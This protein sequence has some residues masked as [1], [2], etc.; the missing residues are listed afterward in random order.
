MKDLVLLEPIFNELMRGFSISNSVKNI[1]PI[2]VE[3][4]EDKFLI[5]AE[6]PGF[7]KEDINVELVDN[8]IIIKAEKKQEKKGRG[9]SEIQYGLFEKIIP[10]A[11]VKEV[12]NAEYKDGYLY[13]EVEKL[14][15]AKKI[16]IK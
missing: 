2:E 7:K 1:I 10:L 13:L 3:E 11:S 16:E 8:K 14:N 15:K 6:M 4:T 12:I 9:Y 5:K